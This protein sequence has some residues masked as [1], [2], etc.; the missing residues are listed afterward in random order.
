M[1]SLAGVVTSTS[2]APIDRAVVTV[3]GDA[4]PAAQ[5]VVTDPRGQFEFARLPAGRYTVSATK[6]AY[7][8]SI[9]G[10]THPGRPGIPVV[11]LP[12]ARVSGLALSMIRGGVISGIVRRSS[13]EP[14]AGVAI[15]TWRTSRD[16]RWSKVASTVTDNRGEYRMAGLVPGD[17]VV[18]ALPRSFGSGE[19]VRMT[20]ADVDAR[21][22]ILKG[23]SAPAAPSAPPPVT[24]VRY[25]PVYS[26]NVL[27]PADAQPITVQP[28]QEH[29]ASDLIVALVPTVHVS[30]HVLER[31]GRPAASHPLRLMPEGPEL[32]ASLGGVGPGIA[33]T[34]GEGRFTFRSMP[35][36]RYTVVTMAAD[37]WAAAEV[38]VMGGAVADVVLRLQ[39]FMT[40]GGRVRF[41]DG[42]R[43]TPLSA[44][45]L[46]VT[47]APIATRFDT[48][49]VP[50][51]TTVKSDG[52][53][54]VAGVWPG[55]YRLSLDADGLAG[56]TV[57]SAKSGIFD[58][59]DGVEIEA[60]ESLTNVDVLVTDQRAELGGAVLTPAGLSP[61]DFCVIAFAVDRSRWVSPR[62]MASTR[63]ATDGTFTIRDLPAGDYWL[64]MLTDCDPEEWRQ[65]GF[66]EQLAPAAV[67]VSIRLGQR[68]TQDLRMR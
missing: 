38:R 20:D 32:P 45:G 68:T 9:Y 40:V 54:V 13:R 39:P 42:V 35:P 18:G 67:R 3:T 4:L 61:G 63:P 31:D 59:L 8:A 43:M 28:E 34:D 60:G 53:F 26:G 12:G 2:D 29:R 58:L 64:A 55:S 48:T 24:M 10:A 56:W 11:L 25:A 36:G 27:S 49:L 37:S 65:S 14:F 17:Y 5:S 6:A 52:S 33:L 41:G 47:L 7:V 66:L 23:G 19:V 62:W 22:R 30:G 21:I 15:T 50:P 46:R 16:G 57:S 1:A 44:T 51:V